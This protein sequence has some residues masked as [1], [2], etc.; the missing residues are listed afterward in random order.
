[1]HSEDQ[2]KILHIDDEVGVLTIT[3]KIF[4]KIDESFLVISTEDYV[5]HDLKGPLQ[6]I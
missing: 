1:M 4:E 2:I 3:K 6:T 5:A